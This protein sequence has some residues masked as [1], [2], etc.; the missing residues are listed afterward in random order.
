MSTN[1]AVVQPDRSRTPAAPAAPVRRGPELRIVPRPAASPYRGLIVSTA[2]IALAT[3]L[4]VLVLNIALSRGSY[5]MARLQNDQAVLS[6][7]EQAL[8]E[9]LA[10]R[11]SPQNLANQAQQLG[12]VPDPSVA[13]LRLS[14]GKVLGVPSP[15]PAGAAPTVKIATPQEPAGKQPGRP[16]TVAPAPAPEPAGN[17]KPRAAAAAGTASDP[18]S[19]TIP[20]PQQTTPGER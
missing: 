10:Y 13:F 14:D 18:A 8:S 3:M 12:M 15:A 6:Q 4:A 11:S 20:A 9:D 17:A 19:G 16:G 7:R 5:H 1:T 2:A